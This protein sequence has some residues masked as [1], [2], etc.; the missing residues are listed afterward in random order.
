MRLSRMLGDRQFHRP[1]TITLLAS[2]GK[3]IQK[4]GPA[5]REKVKA[6][7]MPLVVKQAFIA[8]ESALL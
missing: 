3:V 1:G 4:L 8:A 5:T 6:G 7:K 2:D